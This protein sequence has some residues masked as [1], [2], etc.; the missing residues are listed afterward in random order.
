MSVNMLSVLRLIRTMEVLAV[1]ILLLCKGLC[2]VATAC[3]LPGQLPTLLSAWCIFTNTPHCECLQPPHV[4]FLLPARPLP[5]APHWPR[6]RFKGCHFTTDGF[7]DSRTDLCPLSWVSVDPCDPYL[8]YFPASLTP[9]VMSIRL[10]RGRNRAAYHCALSL[11]Q[12][13]WH[14]HE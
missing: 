5:S 8:G 4:L 3:F 10:L 6:K 9:Q 11:E 1:V 13:A 12:R 14:T 7:P 2:G